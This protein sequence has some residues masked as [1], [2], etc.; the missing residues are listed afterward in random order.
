MT[1]NIA[2]QQKEKEKQPN[3]RLYKCGD[4][5]KSFMREGSVRRH[6]LVDSGR[7]MYRQVVDI[8]KRYF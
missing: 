3:E 7:K 6:T 4:F 1:A 5:D 2:T 8:F